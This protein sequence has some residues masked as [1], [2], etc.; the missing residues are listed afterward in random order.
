MFS[1]ARWRLTIVFPVVLTVILITSGIV[2]YLTSRS[3]VLGRVDSELEDRAHEDL[4]L[5]TRDPF[6]HRGGGPPQDEFDPG[7]Y[8]YAF[9][10]TEGELIDGS[11]YV[12]T[13]SL[14]SQTTLQ[15]ALTEGEAHTDTESSK[16]DPQRIYGLALT[17]TD[18]S[19][20]LL[21]VGRGTGPEESALSQMRTVLLAV[22]G[23]SIVPALAGG[24]L[25]SGRALRPIKAAMDAQHA[26]IA[27]ASHELRT[28][29]A[30]V[31]TNAELLQRHVQSRGGDASATDATA[32]DDIL[33]ESER[34]G[35][36]VDQMLTLAQVDAGEDGRSSIEIP[37]N[38]LA[39]EVARSMKTLAEARG[40]ALDSQTNRA[41]AVRG[42]RERL[43]E[44][45][46]I[47]LDNAI[48]YT[49]SGGRV[50]L[51]IGRPHRRPTITV[52][53]TGHGIPAESLPHIFD[54]F[55]RVDKA[56]SRESGG[57]G[58]GLAIAH[59]I[60]TAHGGTIHIES[61]AGKGTRVTVDLPA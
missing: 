13:Q 8:F 39:D 17:T 34:L 61:T 10:D 33:N 18:G 47:L 54:R 42:N 11:P 37:L 53:D 12:D 45:I 38:E 32:L 60:V 52:S 27:D 15:T 3:V 23:G 58:L 30:V 57:T 28:P 20:V 14:A 19:D 50:D 51:E 9:V 29:V 25:L 36:M 22:I 24:Y 55:Y 5:S 49:D 7:G 6:G 48:K 43:R 16:G 35:R 46:V 26:F 2:V 1:A 31:R 44:L 41:V 40:V 56:R 59:N 21:Q 4:F